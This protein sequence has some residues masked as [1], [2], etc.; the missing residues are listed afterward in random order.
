MTSLPRSP[1]KSGRRSP[2]GSRRTRVLAMLIGLLAVLGGIAAPAA[3]AATGQ[4]NIVANDPPPPPK[5]TGSA[6][7]YTI[8]FTCSDLNEDTCGD[9]IKIRIPL[10]LTSSNPETPAITSWNYTTS[11]AISGLIQSREIVGGEL[12]LTLD[13]SKV[14]PG[15]SQ[16]IQLNV[17][18][19]NNVTPDGT[20]WE[21]EPTLEIDAAAVATAPTPAKGAATAQA[22]ISVSKVTRD[23]SAFVVK[24]R[25]VVYNV[26]ARCNA[27][28]SSG[29]L[30]LKN[31]SLV[32]VLPAGLTYVSATPAPTSVSGQTLTWD[33]P[34]ASALPSGCAQGAGG[35][36]TYQIVAS[37]DPSVT[38]LTELTNNVTFSGT[39]VGETTPAETSAPRKITVLDEPPVGPGPGFVTKGSVGPLS[40]AGAGYIGTY[41]GNWVPGVGNTPATNNPSSAAGRFSIKVRYPAS[42][43]FR[44]DI[45]D[46]MPCLDDKDDVSYQ[47]S[48]VTGPTSSTGEPT[49]D[50]LCDNPAFHPTVVRVETPS[51]A[52]AV[53]DGWRPT[54]VRTDGSTFLLNLV[55]SGSGSATYFSVP[56]AE[57]GDVAAIRLTPHGQLVDAWLDLDVFG[58][59]DES[60]AGGEVLDNTVSVTAYPTN[61]AEPTTGTDD[62]RIA[63][64]ENAPQLGVHKSF[65]GYRSGSGGTT[66]LNLTGRVSTPAPLSGDIVLAD[67]LPFDMSW[68]NAPAS[69]STVTYQLT[70]HAGGSSTPITGTVEHIPNY[71]AT[72]RELIRVT[73]PKSAF[74]SGAY[75]LSPP[76]NFILVSV[77]TGAMTYNNDGY[78]FMKGSGRAT[79]PVCG[80]GTTSTAATFESEDPLDLD[81][82]G[83]TAQNHCSWRASLT[84]PPPSG[85]A[86]GLVKTV[87]G[88][89]DSAPKYSPGI[90][91]ASE[92]GTGEYTVTW[93]NTG[94]R[95]LTDPVIYDILPY[96]GDTGIGVGQVGNPRES[97]FQPEFEGLTAALP[98][99]VVMEYSQSKNPCRDEVL[100]RAS[101]PDCDDDWSATPPSDLKDVRSLRIRATGTYGTGDAFTVRFGVRVPVGYVNVVAWNS[102]ASN[103]KF[104]GDWMLPAEPPKVGIRAPAPLV[105]PTLSTQ[106]SKAEVVT[107]TA[108]RDTITLSGTKG[109]TGDLDWRLVGPK[110]AGSDG[111]C[112]DV[113]WTGAATVASG[114]LPFEGDGDYLTPT[115]T[116]NA[117]GCYSYV[118]KAASEF[119]AA[120][121]EVSHPAGATNEV[122][123]VAP[124]TPE[125]STAVSQATI[126][127]ADTVFDTITL[128]DNDDAS[129]T[130]NWKLVG[131]KPIGPDGSC[132]DVDWIGAAEVAHGTLPFDGNGDYDTPPTALTGAGCYS[133]VVDATSA[134]YDAPVGHPAGAPN[135]VVLVRPATIVTEASS[136]RI[137]PGGEVTDR[138]DLTG[139]GGG[140]GTLEWK[141]VGPIPAN[142]EGTCQNL[143]WVGAQTFDSGTIAVDGDGT[144]VTDPSSPTETGCYSYVQQ[145]TADSAGGPSLSPAGS[146]NEMVYVG[147]PTVSTTVSSPSIPTGGS[148]LDSIDVKGTGGGA[149]TLEWKLYGP[150]VPGIGDTCL[151][152]NWQ[153]ATVVAQG[154]IPVTGDG[155]YLTPVTPPLLLAGCYGYEVTLD[156]KDYGGPVI[157]PAGTPGELSLVKAPVVPQSTANVSIAKTASHKSVSAGKRITYTLTA[158]NRGPGTAENV[159]ITD[160]PQSGMRFVSASPQQGTC[161]TGF[162][163]SCNVGSIPA[164]GKVSVTVVAIPTVAGA[165]VNGARVTTDT[166][167]ESP[168]DE[169][170]A[171]AR[172]TVKVPLRISKR[173]SKKTVRAGKRISYTVRISNRSKVASG[174]A[175]VCDRMP[176]GMVLV[177]VRGAKVT[178]RGGEHCW[179]VPALKPGKSKSYRVVARVLRGAKG[180]QTN[181]VTIKGDSVKTKSARAT[182]RV[183]SAPVRAGGVTG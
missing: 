8:N 62:A 149:G 100:P 153:N 83:V 97:A 25:N 112:A 52:G 174:R 98:D 117:F 183:R 36:Q 118:V 71:E 154:T 57:V 23:G 111:T 127:A 81:G 37:I 46:P 101:N 157:S 92:N 76:S 33:Y 168:A 148:L 72:G 58:Y 30:Y 15:D 125:L 99:G 160:T 107:G 9:S 133:Y 11:S 12:V 162:P 89:L 54:G 19:P 176:A 96:V 20:T 93:R 60:T 69:G 90:G 156:G 109:A 161:S 169:V 1:L 113:D 82:D 18:P 63:I 28:G 139:T 44:S 144:Y 16:T 68:T 49:I 26:T 80:Q 102:G 158:S 79:S 110:P 91:E 56:T 167:N 128:T 10:D 21:L 123:Q 166:P 151:G 129:G 181:R 134:Q 138:V 132:T 105:T 70:D 119:F 35:A 94:G 145:L 5:P 108:V 59:A 150:V 74:T 85:P 17:T 165:V 173:A 34:N 131:P 3:H 55:G 43:A 177:S 4:I 164:G 159:V 178:R 67:L 147:R 32:D 31:G 13:P 143:D 104:N 126:G 136:I 172:I 121:G 29:N 163:L 24:G 41:P 22:R 42:N 65:G 180:K 179:T 171:D 6:S 114:T 116:L 86:F 14:E 120:P 130:L 27:N 146:P 124:V 88:N 87:Q 2:V 61:D 152:L 73:F 137:A 115:T 38:D 182:V 45:V 170:V 53:S 84:V 40:I 140:D 50:E 103:A 66:P 7:S 141:L 77:P 78:T 95:D 135:E 75:T 175:R 142:D 47:S 51:L 155:T 39:P 64:E 106:V 48:P 122:V